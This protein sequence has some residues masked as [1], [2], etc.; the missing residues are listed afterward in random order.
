M[1]I[2]PC[3]FLY[4]SCGVMQ[5]IKI[6]RDKRLCTLFNF[7]Q[8]H[9]AACALGLFNYDQIFR[10]HCWFRGFLFVVFNLR[11]LGLIFHLFGAP[12]ISN[13]V[14]GSC[15]YSPPLNIGSSV[16]QVGHLILRHPKINGYFL[17]IW[18]LI[19]Y[20]KKIILCCNCQIDTAT[21]VPPFLFLTSYHWIIYEYNQP[22][23]Q[24][25]IFS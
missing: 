3:R 10:I 25:L 4:Y 24:I 6:P 15:R 2:Y 17:K 23:F 16:S 12:T 20:N 13:Q 8:Q 5:F 9:W 14:S 21:N 1:K 22:V 7:S 11:Y 19:S 18:T